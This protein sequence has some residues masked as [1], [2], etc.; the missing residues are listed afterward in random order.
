METIACGL[1][2]VAFHGSMGVKTA[3]HELGLDAAID[4]AHQLEADGLA[5]A[6]ERALEKL[7]I[8]C[9]APVAQ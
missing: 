6:M 5:K 9:N 7:S 8:G 4:Y 1:G 3:T 2:A